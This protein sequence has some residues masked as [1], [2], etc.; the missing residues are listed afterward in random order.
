MLDE[1]K[2]IAECLEGK[3]DRFEPLVNAYRDSLLRI[4]YR[5]LG[6]WEEARDAAQETFIKAYRALPTFQ[7]HRHFSTWLHRI[8]INHCLD[9]IK[10]YHRKHKRP[11]KEKI[12]DTRERDPLEKVAETDFMQ[13]VLI[14][15]PKR[16]KKAFIL[17]EIEGFTSREAAKILRCAES[18]V[19]VNSMK[20]KRQIKE[21]LLKWKET[22]P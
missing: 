20:A 8:L 17:M 5:Y 22:E 14:D 19:R 10:S 6:N 1:S 4:A 9:H 7:R 2:I 16:R 11:L 3:P 15:V 12:Q 21:K 18:T 13:K